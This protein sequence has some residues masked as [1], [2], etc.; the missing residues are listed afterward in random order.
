MLLL[1]VSTCGSAGFL[2][3]NNMAKS[4]EFHLDH[5]RQ[6][7]RVGDYVVAPRGRANLGFYTVVALTAKQL[8]LKSIN[9]T[10][11]PYTRMDERIISPSEVLKLNDETVTARLIGMV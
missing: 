6:E 4:P 2:F 1:P 9:Y 10:G 8:R 7:V 5:I 11:N 3:E